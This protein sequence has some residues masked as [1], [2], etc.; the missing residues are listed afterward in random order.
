LDPAGDG[1]HHRGLA[2]A[3]AAKQAN[4]FARLDAQVDALQHMAKAIVRMYIT[5]F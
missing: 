2:H 1:L 5:Q 3:I 4:Y